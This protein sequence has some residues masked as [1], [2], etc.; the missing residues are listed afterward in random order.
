MAVVFVVVMLFF[1]SMP[2]G[3]AGRCVSSCASL[4]LKSSSCELHNVRSR[5]SEVSVGLSGGL[6]LLLVSCDERMGMGTLA[7]WEPAKMAIGKRI[8]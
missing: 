8:E 4:C 3:S 2:I 7:S 5:S 1:L 6:I